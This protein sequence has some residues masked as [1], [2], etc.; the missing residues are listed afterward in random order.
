[1]P[2]IWVPSSPPRIKPCFVNGLLTFKSLILNH[3]TD[4]NP[5]QTS[6]HL[7]RLM[8]ALCRQIFRHDFHS[9]ENSEE[10]RVNL[11]DVI[12]SSLLRC[13]AVRRRLEAIHHLINPSRTGSRN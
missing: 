7:R 11:L 2:W 5:F 13:A 6:H 1:M 12:P 4:V 9:T 10:P 8:F 3:V